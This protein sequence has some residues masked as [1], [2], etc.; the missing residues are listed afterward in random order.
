[1]DASSSQKPSP[2][3]STLQAKPK[4][5]LKN[6][7]VQNGKGG[8]DFDLHAG[9]SRSFRFV[10][11]PEGTISGR[12]VD[13]NGKPIAGID[14][15]AI[16]DNSSLGRRFISQYQYWGGPSDRATDKNGKFTI[17]EL[18]PGGYYLEAGVPLGGKMAGPY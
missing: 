11:W 2:G 4:G 10:L 13:E 15:S 18:K 3:T 1:M 17:G 8:S 16:R 6:Y 14:V 5:Y 7:L 12:I 9:E